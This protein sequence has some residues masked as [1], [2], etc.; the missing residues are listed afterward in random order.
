MNRQRKNNYLV[1]AAVALLLAALAMILVQ[2]VYNVI[3]GGDIKQ[4]ESK[5]EYIGEIE[6]PQKLWLNGYL[7]VFFRFNPLGNINW[8]AIPL[9]IWFLATWKSKKREPWQLALVF[10]WLGI[11]LLASIKGFANARYQL[12]LLPFTIAA[13]L[14]LLWQM[15]ENKHRFL[16]VFV[17]WVV[18]GLCLFNILHYFE[19]YKKLWDLRVTVQRPYFPQQMIDYIKNEKNINRK[20]RFFIIN[21]PVF[22]YHTNKPGKDYMDPSLSR[23]WAELRK[24][25]GS[26]SGVF[27]I[28]KRRHGIKYVLISSFHKRFFRTSTLEEFLHC[29]CR[30]VLE[31]NGRLL[32]KVNPRLLE[33]EIKSPDHTAIK[34][35]HNN[36]GAT[37]IEDVSPSL[38]RLS[39]RGFFKFQL[40]KMPGKKKKQRDKR[41]LTVRML[42]YK[43]RERPRIQLGY[44]LNRRGLTLDVK[45]YAGYYINFIVRAAISPGLVQ[46][47]NRIMVMDFVKETGDWDSQQTNFTTG[48]WRTYKV[49]KKIRPGAERVICF[50]RFSPESGKDRI[51]IADTQ[52]V[53][54]KEPL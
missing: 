39:R 20:S 45:K 8:L 26:R 47:N 37:G 1:T 6:T 4:A 50:F 33:E 14:L 52:I 43:K 5:E 9:L 54:S 42:R 28:F 38:F 7:G 29:D 36:P 11:V 21:Q 41:M 48:R 51:R 16:R 3:D 34:L 31:D 2:Q 40:D 12:T 46:T 15:L 49:S 24:K 35:W 32:Y 44:E 22:Y 18:A 23:A 27:R 53:I 30:L 13:V 10:V 25:D 17:F 19:D